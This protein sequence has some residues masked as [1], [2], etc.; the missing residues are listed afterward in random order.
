MGSD[1]TNTQGSKLVV[2]YAKRFA[3]PFSL[4]LFLA[5]I[6]LHTTKWSFLSPS[7]VQRSTSCSRECGINVEASIDQQVQIHL[8]SSSQ[9][10]IL[11][12]NLPQRILWYPQKLSILASQN[13]LCWKQPFLPRQNH[14]LPLHILPKCFRRRMHRPSKLIHPT[15]LIKQRMPRLHTGYPSQKQPD[16]HA[17]SQTKH[18]GWMM[19]GPMAKVTDQVF[20][21]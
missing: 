8:F 18:M 1:Y 17:S 14:N 4:L 20:L 6:A 3:F 5:L 19:P 16:T 9:F 10:G 2:N 11:H 21:L 12:L 15:P 7:G 13:H